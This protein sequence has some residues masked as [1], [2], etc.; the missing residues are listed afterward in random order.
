M[1]MQLVRTHT[2]PAAQEALLLLSSCCTM[3]DSWSCV[4]YL[5][6]YAPA[7]LALSSVPCMWCTDQM[8]SDILHRRLLQSQADA[9]TIWS[10]TSAGL[11]KL[12]CSLQC[13][14][15]IVCNPCSLAKWNHAARSVT[16]KRRIEK[17]GSTTVRYLRNRV[18]ARAATLSCDR[19]TI[20]AGD[21]A[22]GRQSHP[23]PAQ[24]LLALPMMYCLHNFACLLLDQPSS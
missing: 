14:L 22:I 11:T 1:G 17:G 4:M 21:A 15:V 23:L 12:N 5:N 19:L 3:E 18:G 2:F 7:F 9:S 10:Y 13:T 6:P 8:T 20:G 24:R 16:L